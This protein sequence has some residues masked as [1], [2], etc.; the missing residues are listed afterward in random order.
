MWEVR[1]ILINFHKMTQKDIVSWST[2]IG[3]HA[4]G[5]Y[6]DEAFKYLSLMRK[7]GPKPTEFA[8]ASVLSVC[9][10]MAILEQ[11]KQLHAHCIIVGLDHTSMV[12]SGLI[13]MC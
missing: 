11:G 4:H 1:F 5:G 12:R 10:S 13:N 7:N 3:G 8:F 6:G 2:I 9:G